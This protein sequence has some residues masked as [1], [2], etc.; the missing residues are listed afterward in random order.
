MTKHWRNRIVEYRPEC[1]AAE[2]MDNA[3]NWRLHPDAQRAG[4]VAI[5]DEV[6][7]VD[8]LKAYWSQRQDGLTL[9]DGHL[10]RD[11]KATET[12]PVLILDL[13]D[14]EADKVLA[15]LDPLAAMAETDAALLTAL[16]DTLATENAELEKLLAQDHVEKLDAGG[17]PE[18]TERKE[19]LKMVDMFHALVSIPVDAANR[20]GA[21]LDELE[22]LGA[23]VLY[24]AN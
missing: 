22:R 11:L 21:Q 3:G 4:V 7:K 20:I 13:D 12:W 23:E 5:L 2:L 1:P 8:A 6:G 14:A 15:V 10:R 24:S 18:I 9:V 19:P 17:D 16:V